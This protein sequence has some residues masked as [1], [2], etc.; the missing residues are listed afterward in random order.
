M[1]KCKESWIEGYRKGVSERV[2]SSCFESVNVTMMARLAEENERLQSE[3]ERL[4]KAIDSC[5]GGSLTSCC[6]NFNDA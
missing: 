4:N 2:E 5:T 6:C 1:A 3:V